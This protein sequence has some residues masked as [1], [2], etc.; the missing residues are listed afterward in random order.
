MGAPNGLL[1]AEKVESDVPG[2]LLSMAAVATAKELGFETG[3]DVEPK[4]F[5]TPLVEFPNE[6]KGAALVVVGGAASKFG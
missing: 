2:R 3:A 6:K 1:G 4:E 5:D